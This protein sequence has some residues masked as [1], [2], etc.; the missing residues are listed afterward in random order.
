MKVWSPKGIVYSHVYLLTILF[1]KT[2]V[3]QCAKKG[4]SDSLGQVDFATCIR[5]VNS[6]LKSCPM[7]K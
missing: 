6:V 1:T 7:G 4:M 3:T 5:I 2:Q